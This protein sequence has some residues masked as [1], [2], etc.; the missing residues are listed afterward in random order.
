MKLQITTLCSG[1][2]SVFQCALVLTTGPLHTIPPG[3]SP[4]HPPLPLLTL[5]ISTQR[6]LVMCFHGLFLSFRILV[7]ICY[8]TRI[9]TVT[10]TDFHLLRVQ[11]ARGWGT[12]STS[13]I[14]TPRIVPDPRKVLSK[15]L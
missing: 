7:L 4:Y 11:A 12:G 3:T 10:F 1:L 9:H 5:Q 6:F 15:Y 13:L 8:Y 2:P 14:T